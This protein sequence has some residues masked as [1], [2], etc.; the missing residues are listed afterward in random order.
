MQILDNGLFIK[1]GNFQYAW[2]K[3]RKDSETIYRC[4][5]LRELLVIPVSSKDDYDLLGKQW[6]A[7][8][9]LHNAGVS[10]VYTAMGIYH[11]E[12]IGIVQY[13]GAAGEGECEEDAAKK[14]Q[15]GVS[16]V[17]AVLANYPQS[18]TGPPNPDW[19]KWYL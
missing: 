5:A 14:A 17:E 9:G 11:P 6:G 13:Y 12:H 16:S 18:K 7:L 4:V 3:V 10:F 1:N 19:L 8:R 2:F 15:L